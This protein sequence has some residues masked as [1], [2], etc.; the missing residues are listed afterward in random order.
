MPSGRGNSRGIL[1][2]MAK[3]VVLL[4]AVNVGGAKLPM[5]RLREIASDLGATDVSTYIASGNLL[6]TPSGDEAEFSR[7]LEE[8]IEAEFGF[9]REAITRT[10]EELQSALDAY[11]FADAEPRY[12]HIHF[13]ASEPLP[14][15]FDELLAAGHPERMQLIGRDLHIDFTGRVAGS[16]LSA[17]LLTPRLG[18]PGTARNLRTVAAL[19]DKAQT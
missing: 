13:L 14:G 12:T 9:F 8:R 18:S 2:S 16:K 6:C 11:P 17:P 19:I 4:R 3:L 10:P 1:V 15:A 5:A 7:A